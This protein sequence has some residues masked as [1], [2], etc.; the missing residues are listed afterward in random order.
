MATHSY[1]PCLSAAFFHP[2]APRNILTLHLEMFRHPS[3]LSTFLTQLS[4]VSLSASKICLMLS[5]PLFFLFPCSFF[6][7]PFVKITFHHPIDFLGVVKGM[8]TVNYMFV[9]F[10]FK[11]KSL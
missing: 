2:K 5:L 1:C 9:P 11:W 10:M 8:E 4:L 6:T 3:S 7:P